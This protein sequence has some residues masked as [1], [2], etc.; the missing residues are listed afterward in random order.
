M[1]RYA[2]KRHAL[3][4]CAALGV[5][6]A[7]ELLRTHGKAVVLAAGLEAETRAEERRLVQRARE[8]GVQVRVMN[9]APGSTAP[10]TRDPRSPSP[11][12]L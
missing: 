9:A 4:T 3:N 1:S 5:L 11:L 6:L 7:A 10:T 12:W 2:N 8:R